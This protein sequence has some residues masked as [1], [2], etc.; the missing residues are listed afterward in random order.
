MVQPGGYGLDAVDSEL[1][2][3]KE[4]Y[5][6]KHPETKAGVAGAKA[7]NVV[8]GKC[9]VSDATEIISFASDE[10]DRSPALTRA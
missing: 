9:A 4:L 10:G 1:A 6:L 8:Q 3:R 7:S 2:R 5:E